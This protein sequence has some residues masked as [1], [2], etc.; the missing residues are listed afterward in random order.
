MQPQMMIEDRYF[1]DPVAQK[2]TVDR[3]LDDLE[4][5]GGILRGGSYYQPQS[6]IWYFLKRTGMTST[7]NS[8]SWRRARIALEH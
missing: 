5:R 8:C 6:S 1:Y 4:K 3:Y 2:Y 7:G